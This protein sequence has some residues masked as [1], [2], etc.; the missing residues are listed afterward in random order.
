M[1][2]EILYELEEGRPVLVYILVANPTSI[3][4][5]FSTRDLLYGK[6]RPNHSPNDCHTT[7]NYDYDEDGHAA[8][9]RR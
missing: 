6:K 9:V 8:L 1:L 4:S 5:R 2:E 7:L 3:R